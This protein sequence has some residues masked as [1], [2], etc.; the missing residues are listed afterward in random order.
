MDAGEGAGRPPRALRNATN[1]ATGEVDSAGADGARSAGADG[2]Q[3]AGA[4]GARS[5]AFFDLDK[6]V[7]AKSSALAF[8]GPFYRNG[9]LTRK[10]MLRSAYAQLM[11][12]RSGADDAQLRRIRD[13]VTA[14]I[15]GW[16]VDVVRQIVAETLHELIEP[17]IYAEAA[18]L[19]SEHR[20]AGRDVVIVST[21][22]EEVVAPIGALLGVD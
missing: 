3:S 8:G 12:Q 21:S 22:G 4:D 19:I 10:A 6:T 2:A 14:M 13:A 9:L 7:I 1:G 16:D 18:A 17:T 5:A 20:A 15:T 11:F